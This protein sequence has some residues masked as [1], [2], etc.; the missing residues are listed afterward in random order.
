MDDYI[1]WMNTYSNSAK[2][3]NFQCNNFENCKFI[4]I[5]AAELCLICVRGRGPLYYYLN[6]EE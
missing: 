5:F 1:L 3:P 2:N 6:S 4:Y